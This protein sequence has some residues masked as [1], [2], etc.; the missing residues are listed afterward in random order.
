MVCLGFKPRA[1]VDVGWRSQENPLN[2]GGP[3]NI[4][5]KICR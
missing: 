3:F 5:F 2:C 4:K 1:E